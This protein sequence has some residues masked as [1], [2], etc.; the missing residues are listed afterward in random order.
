MAALAS[1]FVRRGDTVVIGA[2]TYTGAFTI[3]YT[4]TASRRLAVQAVGRVTIDGSLTISG[5]YIDLVGIEI[6]NSGWLDR[7]S[8]QTGGAPTDITFTGAGLTVN[9]TGNRVIGCIIHDHAQGLFSGTSATDIEFIDCLF[10][11]N[12]WKCSADWPANAYGHGIYPQNQTGVKRWR[13]CVFVDN[14]GYNVSAYGSTKLDYMEFIGCTIFGAGAPLNA[15]FPNVQH[16]GTSPFTDP[17]WRECS[18]Y[19]DAVFRIGWSTGNTV[20]NLRMIDNYIAITQPL[21]LILSGGDATATIV[22]NT[23]YA[24]AFQTFTPGDWPGNTWETALPASGVVTRVRPSTAIMGRGKI[25]VFN[26][27]E[28]DSVIVDVSTVLSPGAAYTLRN[29]QDYYT[30][31]ASGNVAGNGTIAIDM[32][33]VSH[34]VAAPAL[35]SAAPT[36]LSVFGAFVLE[37]A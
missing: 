10:Y 15:T 11:H 2:G 27:D 9:G 24:S 6:L 3:P 25:D 33:A 30:D 26:W 28:A 36:T 31:V 29:V 1:P 5:S 19:G 37:S 17:I 13:D 20:T 16:G 8:A 12:G 4:G 32:R 34:S 22:G 21:Q 23:S 7:E 35:F 18:V 14:L